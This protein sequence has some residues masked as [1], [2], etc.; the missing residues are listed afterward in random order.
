MKTSLLVLI[1]AGLAIAADPARQLQ[2]NA[3]RTVVIVETETPPIIR[4]GLLQSTLIVLP[5]EEKVATLFG[6]DIVGWVFDGGHVA[7]RFVSIKP[8]TANASTDVHIVSDHGNDYTFQLKEISSDADPH[9]DSKVFVSPGDKQAKENL[10]QLPVFVPAAEV[11]EKIERLQ[12]EAEAARAA[13]A[14]GR[15]AVETEAEQYRSHYPG[16][17]HFDYVWDRQTGNKLG[18]QQIWRDD[19]FTYLR[20]QFQETPALYELKDGKGSLVNWDFDAGLYTVPKTV[21]Q[22]YLAIGKQR[23]DFRRAGEGN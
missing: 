23:M 13:E 15:K 22:G 3:P 20:G 5:P 1:T 19:K 16:R 21:Y 2:P 14:A 6:G 12:K 18:L 11:Q 10:I 17:L 8:K 9:F 7:S 4:T